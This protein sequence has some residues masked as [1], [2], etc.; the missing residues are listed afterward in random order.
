VRPRHR[1]D[2]QE[3]PEQS[4]EPDA[5]LR[6]LKRQK[7]ENKSVSAKIAVRRSFGPSGAPNSFA[8][9][10]A[11]RSNS[12]LT[13]V[14]GS[15]GEVHESMLV[16]IQTPLASSRPCA[17]WKP[18]SASL[19]RRKRS[20]TSGTIAINSARKSCRFDLGRIVIFG[21]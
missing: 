13:S 11:L 12:Q 2:E 4:Q 8:E 20:K 18:R 7:P 10:K 14:H 5:A 15:S 3:Q 17:R 6:E 1:L 9:P 16:R 21:P 19:S